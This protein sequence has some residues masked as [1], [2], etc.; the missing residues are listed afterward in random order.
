VHLQTIF[1]TEKREVRVIAENH[2]T[3]STSPGV[4][5]NDGISLE[6]SRYKHSTVVPNGLSGSFTISSFTRNA[7]LGSTQHV[8][9]V[10][11][12]FHAF[13]SA[14]SSLE[15]ASLCNQF[16]PLLKT[17]Q[18]DHGFNLGL[19]CFDAVVLSHAALLN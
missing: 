13:S 8:A 15:R 9:A 18:N 14:T 19:I 12:A 3:P 16:F 10:S 17:L 11:Q 4:I 1:S 2:I 6:L 7:K 5:T